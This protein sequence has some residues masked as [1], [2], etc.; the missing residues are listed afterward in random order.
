MWDYT[1]KVKEYFLHPKNVGV[2]E[3]PDAVGD[4]GSISCGDALKL[5]LKIEEGT[6]K[7]LDAKFQTFGCG[8]AI[9]SSS[10][11]TEMIIGR[12]I[13]EAE[14]ITNQDIA[15]FLGGLPKEKMHCSVMGKEALD[16]AIA[17]YRGIDLKHIEEEE[18]PL[19]CQCFGIHEKFIE[20]TVTENDLRTVEDVTNYTKAGGGCQTCHPAIEDIIERV[21]KVKGQEVHVK[22]EVPRKKPS[23]TNL[24]KI[25]L[26]SETIEK[27]IRPA[28]KQ[29]GGDIELIDIDG[30]E[31]I[32]ALRGQCS[33]CVS[34]YY[35]VESI[36]EKLREMVSPDIVIQLQS[37]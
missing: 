2:I 22:E 36:E 16:A 32:V 10:V 15:D 1:D 34:A 12:T 27:E 33:S 6:E 30:N 5:M 26:I 13:P 9:A 7:I 28:L 18:G 8:S 3:N 21:W 35:T 17:D 4:V 14:V 24:Q 37:D 29:D 25:S 23:M 19:V 11:L 20:K 31:V